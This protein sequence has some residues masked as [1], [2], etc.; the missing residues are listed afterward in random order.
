MRELAD[1]TYIGLVRWHCAKVDGWYVTK[2]P[3]YSRT[4]KAKLVT[5]VEYLTLRNLIER[6]PEHTNWIRIKE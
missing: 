4:A 5:A 2:Y 1:E 3:A 6:H